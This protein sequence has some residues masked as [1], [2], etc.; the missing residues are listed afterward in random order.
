MPPPL[1]PSY[2]QEGCI[3]AASRR[4]FDTGLDKLVVR[5]KDARQLEESG[6][7]FSAF[8]TLVY[9]LTS[10]EVRW[11]ATSKFNV[12]ARRLAAMIADGI[13]SSGELCRLRL[14]SPLSARALRPQQHSEFRRC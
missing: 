7:Y 13:T 1:N 12:S 6:P 11:L 9:A 14:T 10:H 2:E 5:R 4:F 8:H 3:K